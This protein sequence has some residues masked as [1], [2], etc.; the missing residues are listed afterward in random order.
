MDILQMLQQH[1]GQLI[2]LEPTAPNTFRIY[3]P[4]FHEDGD[5][6]SMYLQTTDTNRL[7]LRDFGNTLMRVSYTFDIDT[8]NKISILNSIVKSNFGKLDDGEIILETDYENLAQSIFQY[9]QIVAKVSNVDII[10]RENIKSMFN[11]YL[12]QFV[13]EHLKKYDVRQNVTPTKDKQ[14][15][16][17]YAIGKQNPIFLFGVGENTKASKVVIS[18]LSFQK[19]RIPFR[20]LI[21]HEDFD[22]LS[23]FYRN[24]ITNA[25]DKQYTSLDEFQNEGL[26]Y[27]DRQLVS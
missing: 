26:E 19:Q 14:L 2:S 20:S 18:C 21:V 8:E 17:D 11:E 27:I 22:A 10:R 16:V 6:I 23:S 4:F 25:A 24:Q 5:M 3:I 15:L 9:S 13:L 7:L 1:F 12:S